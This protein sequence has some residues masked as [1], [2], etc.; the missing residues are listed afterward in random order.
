MSWRPLS[1]A[2]AK[3]H[4]RY[5]VA[6]W[7]YF[8][9]GAVVFAL[10]ADAVEWLQYSEGSDRPAW[11]IATAIGVHLAILVA[12]IRKWRW[13][14]ELAI[15]G[16]WLT[17][18][19]GQIYTQHAQLGPMPTDVVD[20]RQVGLVAFVFLSLLL[21]WL[22]LASERVNVTYKHRCRAVADPAEG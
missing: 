17:G 1:A 21:T 2:E 7:L 12:G 14:P 6:G 10:I 13:F 16:I 19:L 4:P 11:L 8:F 20:P 22:L 18:A 3:R 5:G 15:G 9:F